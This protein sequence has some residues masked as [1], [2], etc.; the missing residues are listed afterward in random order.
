MRRREFITLLG[1]AAAWPL[2]ARAQQP[3]MPVIGYFGSRS[4][5]SDVPMLAAFRQGLAEIGFIE[6]QNVA[7]EFRWGRGDYGGMPQMAEDLVRRQVAVIVTSGREIPARAAKAATTTIPILFVVGN[8]PV[9]SGLIASFNRPGGN[10][11]GVVNLLRVIGA[12]QLGF[13]RELAPKVTTIAVLTNPNEVTGASQ[14]ADLQEAARALGVKLLVVNA[15]S[16]SD[17]D[18]A[19]AG[20]IQQAG[21]LLIATAPFFLTRAEKIVALA[22]RNGVPAM[23]HRREFPQAGGLVS[24][25]TSTSETYRVLGTYAGRLLKGEKPADLPVQEPT[26]FELVINLKAAKA[27]GVEVPVSMQ[28]LADEVIE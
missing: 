27:I 26:K 4:P 19:F 6:G 25:G 5:E 15:S 13:L 9:Q 24:Y 8:D 17:I 16:D 20:P 7:I 22:A 18:A 14:V 21:A 10:L 28:L 3:T 2:A 23:Y 12:K 1:G 11:T